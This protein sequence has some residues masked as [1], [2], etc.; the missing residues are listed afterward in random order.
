MISFFNLVKRILLYQILIY[1]SLT[2]FDNN[3]IISQNDFF[4]KLYI[5]LTD[6]GFSNISILNIPEDDDIIFR[7]ILITILTISLLSILNFNL[8]QFM[9]GLI[10]I[11]IGFIYY[12]P[13]IKI[14]ELNTKIIIINLF[15][16]DYFI[17]SLD[18]L[19]YICAGI[20]MIYESI[21][22]IDIYYF[23]FCCYL[24][25]VCENEGKRKN[26][27][28]CKFNLQIE[29]ESNNYKKEITE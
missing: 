15:N 13:F 28:K 17:P 7:I 4:N 25:D 18:L 20:A 26:K 1:F 19:I 11:L 27:R 23:I 6:L 12:N 3:I 21:K 14:N 16:I 5:L 22:D 9:S 8:M 29:F 2:K 24:F 10:C